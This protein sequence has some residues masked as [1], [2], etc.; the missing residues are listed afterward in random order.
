M[1]PILTGVNINIEKSSIGGWFL[2]FDGGTYE[3]IGL[4][5]T[6]EDFIIRLNPKDFNDYPIGSAWNVMYN[7]YTGEM[8]LHKI[9]DDLGC[10][11]DIDIGGFI[12]YD[13]RIQFINN[14][15]SCITYNRV[16][17]NEYDQ[18]FNHIES[19]DNCDDCSGEFDAS[20]Y[21]P[22]IDVYTCT[23]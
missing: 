3:E 22:D 1:L 10:N 23:P 12:L 19:V 4:I 7:P 17:T 18:D 6:I 11:N 5:K 2:Y 8:Y 14:E 13:C 15:S 20:Y 21:I 9:G 16:F